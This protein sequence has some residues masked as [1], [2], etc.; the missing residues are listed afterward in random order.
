MAWA[1]AGVIVLVYL[2][3]KWTLSSGYINLDYRME[4]ENNVVEIGEEIQ[5]Y[6]IIENNKFMAVPFLEVS[7]K[8]PKGFNTLGNSYAIFIMPYQRVRRKYSIMGEKRGLYN[9]EMVN[10]SLGDFIGFSSH[11]KYL[12]MKKEII[13]L[14]KK[15]DLQEELVPVGA[16]LGDISVRRWIVDDPLMTIG[17][18]EY[19]G[20][21]PERYIHWPSS[22][23]YNE[24][25][26]KNFDFTTDNSVL[27]ALNIETMKP[28]WEP[29]EEDLI[30]TC[31]SLARGV[32]EELEEEKIPYG[33]ITNAHNDL[34][35]YEKGYYYHPGLGNRHLENLIEIMGR[36]SYKSDMLFEN[37][38]KSIIKKQG[39]Y[40]TVVIITSRILNTYIEPINRLAGVASKTV[41]ISLEDEYLDI[42]PG[43]IIKYRGEI[44]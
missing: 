30:E 11:H 26:V 37:T 41:V 3:N 39:N 32:I 33:L 14:P 36:L 6:S 38:L 9:I 13:I 23:K 5:I 17:I 27:I 15:V 4:I 12:K 35:I 22:M 44:K 40:T 8:F 29:I 1:L 10:F 42:L 7:E 20:N 43:H 18:R 21:E 28:S 31:I 2:I 25:M 19:T 16:L 24:L 34:S